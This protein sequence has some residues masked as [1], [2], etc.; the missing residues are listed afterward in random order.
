MCDPNE[1]GLKQIDV[2]NTTLI[3]S[4]RSIGLGDFELIRLTQGIG[5][6][7]GYDAPLPVAG[8]REA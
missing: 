3:Q 1:I 7:N 5:A 8:I 6:V 2:E 4:W